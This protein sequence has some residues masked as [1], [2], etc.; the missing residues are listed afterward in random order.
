MGKEFGLHPDE[1]M[2]KFS[3]DDMKEWIALNI[4]ENEDHDARIK[5][6]QQLQD[7]ENDRA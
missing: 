6:Q 5:K 1:V 2:E 3:L 4:I 7:W